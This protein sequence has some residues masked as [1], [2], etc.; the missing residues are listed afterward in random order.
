M[1]PVFVIDD[2]LLPPAEE[3]RAMRG[4]DTI[5]WESRAFKKSGM[6]CLNYMICKWC[7]CSNPDHQ[8]KPQQNLDG[9]T[10]VC[11]L[12]ADRFELQCGHI[13]L[14]SK[15]K[16][17]ML[18]VVPPSCQ[19]NIRRTFAKW[20]RRQLKAYKVFR[21]YGR[22]IDP[23]RGLVASAQIGWILSVRQSQ[24]YASCRPPQSA[25]LARMEMVMMSETSDDECVEVG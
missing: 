5:R 1:A 16:G 13:I 7:G 3:V 22:L 23:V 20:R 14:P 2:R 19:R 10:R 17:N 24:S 9:S 8:D 15:S 21:H 25:N 18:M 12:P 4:I 6:M 11:A